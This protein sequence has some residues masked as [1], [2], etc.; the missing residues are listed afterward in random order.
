MPQISVNNLSFQYNNYGEDIFKDVSFSIDTDWKL[1]LIGR[2]GRGKTTFLK[3]LMGEYEYSGT[4]SSPVK[5]EYF[6][7]EVRNKKAIALEVIRESIAPFALWEKQINEFSNS[8]SQINEYG[9][10][11]EKFI[12]YDGYIINEMIEKEVRKM[13]LD[14]DL[15]NRV[16]ETLSYGEQNKLLLIALFLKK[17]HFLLIDE[18]TN[19]LDTN[20]R[21]AVSKYLASK[22]GFIVVSHDRNFIDN[23]VNH[24]LSIN[25]CSI[26]VQKG[27]FST[28][29]LNKTRQDE[30]EKAKNE[31]LKKE[32]ERLKNASIQKENWAN[33]T[34]ASKNSST[35][36]DKGYI[37]HKAAKMM[38]RAKCI[39]ARKEKFINEKTT[40]LKDCEVEED[41]DMLIL[42][43]GNDT[44]LD[45]HNLQIFYDNM[46]LFSPLSFKIKNGTRLWLRGTNGCGKSSIIKSILNENINYS[47]TIIKPQK[48]SYISQD[49]SFLKGT[50]KEFIIENYIDEALIKSTL[51]KMGFETNQYEKNIDEWSEGQ[52]KKLLIAKSLCEKA[53]LFIWDEPL[54]FLDII[55]RLQI[56]KL[57]CNIKPTM[58]FVEHD[59]SFGEK[60]ATDILWMK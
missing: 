3:L 30:F 18:P 34:E 21:I 28:W 13:N 25:K 46:P 22:K 50:L 31:K 37:G 36:Y 51:Y 20:G 10:V 9:E 39:N 54:N 23:T 17:N 55:S 41:L 11:L 59:I 60:I 48:I 52:K 24:I 4:I 32:I 56:E 49:T 8:P 26:N 33:Q 42:S 14:P 57:I 35:S 2:N 29:Q 43:E 45:I 58:L 7:Y 5:F 27:N 47:G 44:I 40:L 6:P 15:L 1:A 53:E 16:F 38:K 19:H 12:Y